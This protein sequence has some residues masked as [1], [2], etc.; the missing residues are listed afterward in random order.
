MFKIIIMKIK[1]LKK[2]VTPIIAVIMLLLIT[3]SLAGMAMVIF[4]QLGK[5]SETQIRQ[6]MAKMNIKGEIR[7]AIANP[8]ENWFNFTIINRYSRKLP[9][10]GEN[11]ELKISFAGLEYSCEVTD[12][13]D[14]NNI[15]NNYCCCKIFDENGGEKTED[16]SSTGLIPNEEYKAHCYYKEPFDIFT[17]YQIVWI[18]KE[19]GRELDR[20]PIIVG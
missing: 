15:P 8:N 16:A 7:D 19:D 1:K 11:T 13:C 17:D 2:S 3:L 6:Q 14:A 9:I 10:D 12:Q 18:Y 20:E 5:Q 4:N